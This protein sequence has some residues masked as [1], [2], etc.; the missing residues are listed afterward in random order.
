MNDKNSTEKYSLSVCIEEKNALSIF[1]GSSVDRIVGDIE[2]EVRGFAFDVSSAKGRKDIASMAHKVS[3]SKTALDGLG[4]SLVGDWKAKAKV[5]DQERKMLRDRLDALRDEVRRPL[6]EWEE[7]EAKRAEEEAI[8]KE[9]A[10]AFEFAVIENELFDKSREIQRREEEAEKERADAARKKAAEEEEKRRLDKEARIKREAEEA[11]RLDAERRIKEEKERAEREVIAAKVAEEQAK[12]RSKKDAELAEARRL[13]ELKDQKERIEREAR[14][15]AE[16]E[17]KEA[18]RIK[19]AEEKKAANKKH[20]AAVNNGILK[21]LLAI[22]ITE[23]HGKEI[24]TLAAK[25]L[26]KN[27]SVMY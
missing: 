10:Q 8:K 7:A 16:R 1:N 23:E 12:E 22:G 18:A 21:E 17:E 20:R 11:A 5:V 27:L 19:A 25:G 9:I 26:I 4:K 3:R 24:V 13:K 2:D 14:E 6:T 15:K